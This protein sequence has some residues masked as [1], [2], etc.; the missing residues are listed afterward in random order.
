MLI[1]VIASK[2]LPNTVYI[3]STVR[4]KAE[5]WSEHE[6]KS[7]SCNSR[8]IMAARGAE[9]DI[10]ETVVDPSVILVD[11]EFFY[12]M[13][14][15]DEGFTVLNERMP[16]AVA[17]AG[18]LSAYKK[19]QREDNP[20]KTKAIDDKNNKQKLL[21][22][23][24]DNCGCMSSKLNMKAHKRTKR[25]KSASQVQPPTTVV[26]NITAQTVHVYN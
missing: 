25:C 6:C 16:G 1:Y 11:R 18:G 9:M 10:L 7:N 26:N 20:E 24:C 5:R 15:T 21:P 12:I 8:K 17:R 22:L 23:K 4:T 14:F 13:K 3:G 19:K 2:N